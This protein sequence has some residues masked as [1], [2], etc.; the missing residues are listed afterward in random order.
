MVVVLAFFIIP[1]GASELYRGLRRSKM[2]DFNRGERASDVPAVP[3]GAGPTWFI[4]VAFGPPAQSQPQQEPDLKGPLVE[5]A[6]GA[7]STGWW[8][9]L[10][11]GRAVFTAEPGQSPDS[12]GDLGAKQVTLVL[13]FVITP[14]GTS[15]IEPRGKQSWDQPIHNTLL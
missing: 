8:L 3:F 7:A 10:G 15:K 13:A 6:P 12:F 1:T 9:G 11:P 5:A 4:P 14:I 2:L